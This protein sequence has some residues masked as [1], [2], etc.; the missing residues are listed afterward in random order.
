M[1]VAHHYESSI[2]GKREYKFFARAAQ[3]RTTMRCDCGTAGCKAEI[4]WQSDGLSRNAAEQS[5]GVT[6]Y[7]GPDGQ[8]F[9][10]VDDSPESR[11]SVPAGYT[12]QRTTTY[13]ETQQLE[14]RLNAAEQR[15]SSKAREQIHQLIELQ[16]AMERSERASLS[17]ERM[18][19]LAREERREREAREFK[20][21]G[22]VK[23]YRPKIEDDGARARLAEE[24]ARR[25]MAEA[26]RTKSNFS[27][28]DPGIHFSQLHNDQR[29]SRRG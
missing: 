27:A 1:P 4:L 29:G 22:V 20:E 8:I 18:A 17:A 25:A 10:P 26:N 14:R 23:E 3:A 12:K 24:L 7:T 5:C 19:A 16:E 9:V 15:A 21:Y 6:Y 28:I 13:A 11:A 2:C